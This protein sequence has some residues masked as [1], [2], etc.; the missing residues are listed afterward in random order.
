MRYEVFRRND[1]YVRYDFKWYGFGY[2]PNWIGNDNQPAS[3]RWWVNSYR[4]APLS[5][6][7]LNHVDWFVSEPQRKAIRLSFCGSYAAPWNNWTLR[8]GRIGF[9]GYAPQWVQRCRRRK[10]EQ[11][12]QRWADNAPDWL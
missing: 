9:G 7:W 1:G 2:M 10:A 8:I 5:L 4:S 12:M 3:R 6:W 11:E